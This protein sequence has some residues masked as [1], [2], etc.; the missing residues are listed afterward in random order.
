MEASVGCLRCSSHLMWR[1][2]NPY[3]DGTLPKSWPSVQQQKKDVVT[4]VA[5]SLSLTLFHCPILSNRKRSKHE[6][7]K[8]DFRESQ[9]QRQV[10]AFVYVFGLP[11]PPIARF[12]Q[13]SH[14]RFNHTRHGAGNLVFATLK[15]TSHRVHLLT[16]GYSVVHCKFKKEY[17]NWNVKQ[18]KIMQ[19]KWVSS[20]FSTDFCIHGTENRRFIDIICTGGRGFS[21][22]EQSCH[23]TRRP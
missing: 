8:K 2:A 6:F 22:A 16:Q 14:I 15:N 13:H 19:K 18:R 20:I 10:N 12:M 11:F 17:G 7:W 5:R 21:P 3:H 4:S 23:G 9:T 1:Y